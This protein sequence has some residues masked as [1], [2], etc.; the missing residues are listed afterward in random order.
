MSTV[1]GL[2]SFYRQ[3]D[4]AYEVGLDEAALL[5]V[6]MQKG[7]MLPNVGYGSFYAAMGMPE[8][9]ERRKERSERLIA[10]V[11]GL[12]DA[13]R[14]RRRPVL[15]CTVAYAPDYA[16]LP[17]R[18]RPRLEDC[19]ARGIEPPFAVRGS[20]GAELVEGLGRLPDE[21]LFQKRTSGAFASTEL[22]AALRERGVKVLFVVGVATNYCVETTV[23]EAAD[24]DYA[25]FV[26]EDGCDAA[27]PERHA[28]GIASLESVARIVLAEDV[29]AMF[30]GSR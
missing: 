4:Q 25:C 18:W 30:E 9:N 2:S 11:R 6:D 8:L 14:R 29:Y 7:S 16:D 22:D 26:V 15:Y 27:T 1:D 19:R 21:P 13:F 28:L 10:K 23:R 5:V 20:E 17:R 3:Q 24:R 12:A